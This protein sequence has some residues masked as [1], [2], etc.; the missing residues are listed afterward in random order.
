[1]KELEEALADWED[2]DMDAEV[3]LPLAE[4][5]AATDADADNGWAEWDS[6]WEELAE[7]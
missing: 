1:M 3:K 4:D 7:D 5:D 2:F 6:F